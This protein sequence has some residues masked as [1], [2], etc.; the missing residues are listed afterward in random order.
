MNEKSQIKELFNQCLDLPAEQQIDWVESSDFPKEVKQKVLRLLKH[1]NKD[2][3]ISNQLINAVKNKLAIEDLKAGNLFNEFELVKPIGRGGQ[4]DVWLAKRI[5]GQFEQQVAIKI[6]KPIHKDKDE[7]RFLAE[8]SLLAQLSHPHIAQLISGGEYSNDRHYMVLEWID[9]TDIIEYVKQKKLTLKQRLRLFMQVCEAVA[10]AHQN[11]I[12]HRDIKPSNVMV[13]QNG[14]VKLLDFGVAKSK[15][16]NLT[17]TQHE[18]ML[19]MAYASP[20]QLKGEKVSTV[21]DVYSLGLLLYE[22]LTEQ[23]AHKVDNASPAQ[24]IDSITAQIPLPPSERM[25][26]AEDKSLST[27]INRELDYL[28]LMALRKEPERRYQTV[29]DLLQDLKNYLDHKP[30]MAGGDSWWYRSKKFLLR[31]PVA[32]AMAVLLLVAVLF[33][34]ILLVNFN[35]Q[36]AVQRDQALQAQQY[37]ESQAQIA[38]STRDFLITLLKSASPLGSGGK[39]ISLQD[40][41]ALGERQITSSLNNQPVL[42]TSLLV[43]FASIQHNLGDYKKAYDYYIRARDLALKNELYEEALIVDAQLA[44]N[45]TWMSNN[46]LSLA[47]LDSGDQLLPQVSDI[48]TRSRYYI[49]KSTCLSNMKRKKEGLVWALKALQEVRQADIKDPNLL[50]RIHNELGVAYANNDDKKSLEHHQKALE[51]GVQVFGKMHPHT[52]TRIINNAMVYQRLE[53]YE[54]ADELLSEAETIAEK[55][56]PDNHPRLGDLAAERAVFLHDRGAFSKALPKYQRAL[57]LAEINEGKES[58]EYAVRLNNIAYLYEDLGRY[59]DAEQGYR[60]SIRIRINVWGEDSYG[61]ASARSNLARVLAK[62]NQLIESKHLSELAMPVYTDKGRSNLYNQVTLWA[63]ELQQS[64]PGQCGRFLNDM[65]LF[66]NQLN[67]ESEKS[68]RR[69]GAEL[70]LGRLF[71][72]CGETATAKKLLT[73]VLVLV[74]NIYLPDSQGYQRVTQQVHEMLANL[75]N[76]ISAIKKLSI[77]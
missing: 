21:T 61:V 25:A 76:Q 10:Y 14:V 71:Y 11:G 75:N 37:A 12:I 6:L 31:N 42:K 33:L 58:A 26:F 28:V 49:I 2:I 17:E 24:L 66:L 8:R 48:K 77:Q 57:E 40:V 29:N 46:E 50:G 27:K 74:D 62:D 35:R 52:H 9:G 68:W 43:T 45:A 36:L 22:L 67:Q 70:W 23:K 60:E 72:Q 15:D 16:L 53:R 13:D 69:L 1:Q 3:N 59:Q 7:Q 47:H 55:L 39:D 19:T 56:Y 44:L 65:Q 20:E 32:T 5:D 51:F 30:L 4:G 34:Q 18:Q 64:Q 73:S 41:L 63:I 54:K 38:N